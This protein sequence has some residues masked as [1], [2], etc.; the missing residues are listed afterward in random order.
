MRMAKPVNENYSQI[1]NRVVC[2]VLMPYYRRLPQCIVK[3]DLPVLPWR[4]R[5]YDHP[6]YH[7]LYGRSQLLPNTN[8]YKRYFP[9][10]CNYF[11]IKGKII[12][13]IDKGGQ[14]LFWADD[15]Y[16]PLAG[17]VRPENQRS[18]P[19]SEGSSMIPDALTTH[20]IE[21]SGSG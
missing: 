7:I 12:L 21:I 14:G 1:D 2:W 3:Q 10:A 19:C 13:N 20:G 8:I 18:S 17:S 5:Q 16:K 4:R 6:K 9:A 15:E 11:I